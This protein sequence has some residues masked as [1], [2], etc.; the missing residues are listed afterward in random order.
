MGGFGKHSGTFLFAQHI[1]QAISHFLGNFVFADRFNCLDD[2][3]CLRG[4]PRDVSVR[5]MDKLDRDVPVS[6]FPIRPVAS[7]TPDGGDLGGKAE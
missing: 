2:Q 4:K 3:G 6:V 1:S 7:E 5:G